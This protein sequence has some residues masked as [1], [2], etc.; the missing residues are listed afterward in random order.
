MKTK[1]P[2]NNKKNKILPVSIKT[3]PTF[4]T[5]EL[6]LVELSTKKTKQQYNTRHGQQSEVNF[7]EKCEGVQEK[8]VK[9]A[10]S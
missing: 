9:V 3:E 5:L 7:V 4:L 2:K 6:K 10:L 8:P 1:V